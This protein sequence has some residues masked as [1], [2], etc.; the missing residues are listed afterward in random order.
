MPDNIHK[1]HRE[2]VRKKFL[3]TKLEGFSDIEKLEFLLFYARPGIDTNVIAHNL[4]N[5]FKTIGRVFDASIEQLKEVD[6]ISEATAVLIKLIPE[7]SKEYINSKSELMVMDNYKT[8][9]DYFKSQ[10]VGERN[11]LIKVAC[12]DDK[13]RLIAC[14]TI[15]E[16]TP[17]SALVNIRKLVEFTY[18]NNCGSIILAHN[19]PNGD[20]LPSDEDIKVTKNMYK[21]LK[22]IGIDLIDHIIVAGGQAIS[23]KESGVFT[24]IA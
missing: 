24:V 17:D 19:H 6:G 18:K 3:K 11:E 8:V 20:L 14:E 2:R 7:M 12:V 21:S 9:R 22:P 13:L 5:K 10:F 15:S 4:I 16:G 23:L 1:G